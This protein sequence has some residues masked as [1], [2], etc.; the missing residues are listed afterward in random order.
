MYHNPIVR[1]AANKDILA[2]LSQSLP[3]QQRMAQYRDFLKTSCISLCPL[4]YF[5]VLIF[6]IAPSLLTT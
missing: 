4:G 2:T 5:C 3:L 1:Q 6:E